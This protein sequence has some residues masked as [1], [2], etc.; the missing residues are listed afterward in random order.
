MPLAQSS[1]GA[2][3]C[4]STVAP[5]ASTS[6]CSPVTLPRDASARPRGRRWCA[7]ASAGS[8]FLSFPLRDWEFQA[9]FTACHPRR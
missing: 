2:R 3:R 1:T 5:C 4:R 6:I 9:G 7:G 8:R